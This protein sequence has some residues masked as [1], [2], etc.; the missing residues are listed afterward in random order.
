VSCSYS[1]R[2]R[3]GFLLIPPPGQKGEENKGTVQY[4]HHVSQLFDQSVHRSVV[5]SL[6]M[7]RMDEEIY[8]YMYFFVFT[9]EHSNPSLDGVTF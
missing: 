3:H 9:K 7:H 2:G 1:I 6:I 4:A 5:G 8:F